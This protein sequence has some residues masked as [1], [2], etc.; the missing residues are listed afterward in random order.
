MQDFA[1]LP[2]MVL[3]YNEEWAKGPLPEIMPSH[4]VTL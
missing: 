4:G 1:N 2:T 3:L